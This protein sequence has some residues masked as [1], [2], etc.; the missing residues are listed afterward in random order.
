MNSSGDLIGLSVDKSSIIILLDASASLF[1]E[2]ITENV[3]YAV[4]PVKP[5]LSNLKNGPQAQR[6]AKWIVDVAPKDATFKAAAFQ[7][8]QS[9]CLPK[10]AK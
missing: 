8:Q 2:S 5:W 4:N 3:Y 7:K 10:M 9:R 1:S 6:I